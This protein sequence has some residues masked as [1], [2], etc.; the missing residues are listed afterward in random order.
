MPFVKKIETEY[1]IIGIWEISESAEFL[2][3]EYVFSEEEKFEF[4]KIKA[5]K[6]RIE[7]VVIRLLIQ[8]ILNKKNEI[9]YL[10][11]G[12]PVLHE[13]ELNISISHSK[14]LVVV[15]ISD[16][17]IGIDTEL[18]SRDID[19]VA[20]RFLNHQEL[21]NIIDTDNPQI[22]KIIYW[23][24]KESIFKCT[25]YAG[26]QYHKQIHISAFPI[27]KKGKFQGKLVLSNYTEHYLL[28]YLEFQNNMIVFCVEDKKRTT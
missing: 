3:K 7:Y 14:N 25:D 10:N 22:A 18:C 20:T 16:I 11:S 8:K 6:R 27:K 19:R 5:E 2:E 21:K 13:N 1:G 12:K 17:Q 15:M 4:S 28:W 24:A 23:G 26:I 9:R